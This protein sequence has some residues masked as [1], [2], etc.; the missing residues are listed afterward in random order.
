VRISEWIV[1]AYAGYLMI[2]AFARPVRPASRAGLLMGA[3]ALAAV[4][5]V[6]AW[7][8]PAWPLAQ[9]ARDFAP[10]AYLLA[11]YKLSGLLFFA[12]QPGVEAR[13]ARFD[14]RVQRAFGMPESVARAPRLL[15]E[16]LEASYFACYVALPAGLVALMA[17]GRWSDADRYWALVLVATLAC[18]G[19]LPWIR[20]RAPWALESRGPMDSRV[21]TMRRLNWWVSRNASIQVNTFPSAHTAASLAVALAVARAS[22]AAGAL[23]LVIA[24]SIAAATFVGRYHYAGDSLAAVATTLLAWAAASVIAW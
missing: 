6:M 9:L 22:P 8:P 15:A 4:V 11:C 19:M 7:A 23:F 20:T 10:L 1:L 17:G 21:V 24:I 2:A 5:V 12:P 18:Y 3:P 16:F 13:F 14:A